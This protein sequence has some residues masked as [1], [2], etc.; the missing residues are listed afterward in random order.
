MDKVGYVG[1]AK[2][3]YGLG[4]AICVDTKGTSWRKL[5]LP[6]KKTKYYG[7]NLKWV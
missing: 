2:G 5:K 1:K 6:N 7:G 3:G 4:S